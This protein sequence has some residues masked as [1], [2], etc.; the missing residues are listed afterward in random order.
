[1]AARH[2]T[3]LHRRARPVLGSAFCV[4]VLLA[5]ACD[6]SPQGTRPAGERAKRPPVELTS[7]VDHARATIA[8]PFRFRI[9]LDADP[10]VSVELPEVGSRI[11]GLRI[12]DMGEDGPHRVEG[13]NRSERWYDLRADLTG[14]YLLPAVRL[15][16]TDPEGR[17][18]VAETPQIFVEIES[19]LN[20]EAGKDDIRDI[21]P[22]VPIRREIP[23]TWILSGAGAFLLLGAG[24][25]LLLMRRR[26]RRRLEVLLPPEEIAL[27]D[28]EHLEATGLLEE[29]R[30]R[31]YVFGLSLIF[32]RYVERKYNIP[33]AEQTTEEL[34]AHL[35]T[36]RRLD[37]STKEMARS[38]LEETDPI[39]YRGLDPRT[40]ET[41]TWRTC[42]LAFLERGGTMAETESSAEEV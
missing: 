38:F 11:Q 33:A 9:I 12:V 28:L 34:L 16:Y 3:I 10:R 6:R 25:G 1:M 13:R 37:G 23:W 8:Q 18:Q 14:S 36:T 15:P 21:K 27:R 41:E 5:L 24:V 2:T 35:R 40:E 7:E 30:Y 26:R 22:L 42:L 39:K 20:P 19:T 17:E 4:L 32:R 31:E 29:E